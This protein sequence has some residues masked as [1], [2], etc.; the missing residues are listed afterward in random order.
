VQNGV[1]TVTLD[2]LIKAALTNK[3]YNQQRLG[4][5]ARLYARRLAK[6][7]AGDFPEDLHDE[8]FGQAFVE[9]FEAGSAGLAEYSGRALFR[10]AV[11]AA[12]RAVRA[13]YAPPGRR[14]R[15]STK[16]IGNVVAAEDVGHI[17]DK[18]VIERCTVLDDAGS[19]FVD[20]DRFSDPGALASQQNM[21][22][23][24]EVEQILRHAPEEVRGALRLIYLDDE[25][26][27]AVAAGL[28]ITRFSL[29][30][31]ISGFCSIWRS[32]A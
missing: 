23:Q 28:S 15:L 8:V 13:S 3:P 30:R 25:S 4:N 17:A 10:R 29:N 19:P 12:I 20:F 7:Y 26:V 9:L 18:H 27:E 16:D 24:L 31:R 11:L 14:T 22:D 32:A 6:S 5:Q 21:E 1:A 2:D